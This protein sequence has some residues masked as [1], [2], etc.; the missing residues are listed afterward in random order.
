MVKE[1]EAD[2]KTFADARRTLIQEEKKVTAEI[3]VVDEPVT[4]IVS[5][6]GWVR[7]HKGHGHEAGN[8]SLQGGRPAVRHV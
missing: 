4:V 5:E 3:K 8:F 7:T 1:I 6:K 2:A